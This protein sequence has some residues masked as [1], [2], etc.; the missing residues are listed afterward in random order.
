MFTIVALFVLAGI[1]G[2]AVLWS[3]T[4][5][6]AWPGPSER[7]ADEHAPPADEPAPWAD[8]H[9]PD[10]APDAEPVAAP[11]KGRGSRRRAAAAAAGAT[12]DGV[13]AAVAIMEHGEPYAPP[14]I[15]SRLWAMLRLVLVI[16]V[17]CAAVAGAIY[18][19]ASTLSKLFG[20]SGG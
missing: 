17:A 18:L 5:Q 20:H 11:R 4:W 3:M 15:L 7:G 16:A 2:A 6:S 1:A 12:T 19:V 10:T 9:V 8:E 14:S 13:P